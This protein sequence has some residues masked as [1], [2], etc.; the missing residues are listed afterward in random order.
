MIEYNLYLW[1]ALVVLLL[2]LVYLFITG[3]KK[4]FADWLETI[5]VAGIL[6]LIIRTFILATFFIPSGSMI[7]T[8]NIRDRVIGNKFIYKFYQPRRQD[9]IIFKYPVDEKIYFVKR[10]IGFPG[11]K[12]EIK[13]GNI[14][15]NDALLNEDNYN[16]IKDTCNF[17]PILV[18]PRSYFVLG[19]NRGNS[20]DSRYWGF[21]PEKNLVAQAMFV[22]WPLNRLKVAPQ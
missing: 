12:I 2:Y 9:I 6:A 15:I 1:I 11:D 4:E 17:G 14:F 8:F 18:P 5:I 20:A 21:V 16:I 22:F 19:D 13:N 7:P 10:L 3:H